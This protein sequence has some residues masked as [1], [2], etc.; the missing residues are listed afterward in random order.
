MEDILEEIVGEI[1]D[2]QDEESETITKLTEDTY[3]AVSS[4]SID[5]F[6]TYFGLSKNNDISSSTL[7]GWI[8]EVCGAIAP[9]GFSFE[10][11]GL[12]ITVTEA[13]EQMTLAVSVNVLP[14]EED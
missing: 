10:Y 12:L 6:F 13:E 4:I 9:V 1:W 11:S 2:E 8:C 3:K 7:N 5:E 14:R